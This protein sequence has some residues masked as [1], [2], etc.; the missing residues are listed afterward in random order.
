MTGKEM[1]N[2]VLGLLN[3]TDSAGDINAHSN[4]IL[5][6]RS[7]G[8]INQIYADLWQPRGEAV[9]FKPITSMSQVLDL[10][11]Y[12]VMNIMPYGVAMLLA[13][14]EGDIDNQTV[15]ASLYNQRRPGS[16]TVSDRIADVMPRTCL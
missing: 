11:A 16:V 9:V 1:L 3:Y 12:T 5:H 13:Q 8:I 4:I 14:T 6:K 10:D 2:H 15:F 7:L